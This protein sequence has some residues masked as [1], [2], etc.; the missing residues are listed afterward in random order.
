MLHF[1]MDMPFYLM[2]MYGSIMIV[3]VLLLRLLWRNRL[4]KFVFPALW[5]VV[6][7]RFLIPYSLSSPLSMP[8]LPNPFSFYERPGTA[9]LD[10][11]TVVKDTKTLMPGTAQI[12]SEV[13]NENLASTDVIEIKQDTVGYAQTNYGFLPFLNW[14]NILLVIYF[15]GLAVLAGVLSWQKYGYSE[16]LRKGLL[17]E[18]NETVNTMLRSMD[19]GHVLIFSNDEIASPLVSGLWNPRIYLPTKMNF[20]N[21]VL[22]RYVLAHETAHIRRKDNWVKFVMLVVLCLNWYNPLVWLMSKCL[23]SDLEAA[24]DEAVLRKCGEDE[25]KDYAFSLLAMAITGSR[26]TLLYSAFSKT[27]VE[28]RVKNIIH[29]KK[30]TI[31]VL[32]FSVLFMAGSTAVFATGGQAPF[33]SGLSAYCAS[34]NSRWGVKAMITRDISLG[35]DP[36]RRADDVIF[37]VLGADE[38]GDPSVIEDRVKAALAEEFGVERGAFDIMVSLCLSREELEEEYKVF[39]ISPT[40]DGFWSYE[41]EQVRTYEDKMLG[42]CQSREEG[43]VDISVQRNRLGEV[44]SVTVWRQGDREFDERTERIEQY[45]LRS[46][47]SEL[48]VYTELVSRIL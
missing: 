13:G 16:K 48:E 10:A 38:T 44:S 4:P 5:G 12:P 8:V 40:E 33:S 37:S 2:A 15:G 35:K 19:M 32:L 1:R 26:S 28:K 9:V 46:Y 29:Y 20:Q 27:E 41:G 43:T 25:R 17:I 42:S 24:C 31:F 22:L 6:L 18:N 47:Y 30:A 34:A 23:A 7:L 39:G 14:Q 3:A 45:K 11:V 36:Q 21:T